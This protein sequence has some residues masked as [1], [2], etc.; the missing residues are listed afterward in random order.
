MWVSPAEPA[1]LR[2]LGKVSSQCE[3]LGCDFLFLVKDLG[4]V[5]VQRKEFKDLIA[6]IYDGRLYKELSQMKQ[7]ARG[8]FIIE[9]MPQWTTDGNYLG[10]SNFNIAQYRGILWRLQLEGHWIL[11]TS[12]MDETIGSLLHFEKWMESHATQDKV[13]SLSKK[14]NVKNEWGVSTNKEWS[15][16]ILTSFGLGPTLAQRVY[17]KLGLPIKWTVSKEELMTVDGIGKHRAEKMIRSLGGA[18]NT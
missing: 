2:E 18:E 13:S 3:E 16:S 8:M 15:V 1:R 7:L 17:E 4:L 10:R 6:S 5:G 12:S 11:H 9:G 14:Q